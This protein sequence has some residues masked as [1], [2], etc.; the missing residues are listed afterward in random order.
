MIIN[1]SINIQAHPAIVHRAL[2]EERKNHV[3]EV[4]DVKQLP[5]GVITYSIYQE[6]K[7]PLFKAKCTFFIKEIKNKEMSFKL[8]DSNIF[9]KLEGRWVI[10]TIGGGS[11]LSLEVDEVGVKF[12]PAPASVIKAVSIKKIRQSLEN[13]KKVSE[14]SKAYLV[15]DDEIKEVSFDLKNYDTKKYQKV[16]AMNETQAKDMWK[17]LKKYRNKERLKSRAEKTTREARKRVCERGVF[18]FS[19]SPELIDK[20]L[21]LAGNKKVPVGQMV[22]EWV[23]ERANADVSG[24]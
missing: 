4:Y 8:T 7:V 16:V 22:R 17:L 19:A 9:S 2:I 20:L 5:A 18:E 1:E 10:K 13:I 11:K 12:L 15:N 6:Y 3:T 14:M 21:T 23:E 24:K